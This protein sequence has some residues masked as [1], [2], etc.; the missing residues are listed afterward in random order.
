MAERRGAPEPV[1]DDLDDTADI[2]GNNA[3]SE[4]VRV[5]VQIKFML[6]TILQHAAVL[7]RLCASSSPKTV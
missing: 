7:L 1:A 2:G 5:A 6:Q 4:L 3:R